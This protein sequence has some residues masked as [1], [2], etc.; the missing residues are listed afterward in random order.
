MNFLE[1]ICCGKDVYKYKFDKDF[2]S[3]LPNTI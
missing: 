1:L 3:L 2:M